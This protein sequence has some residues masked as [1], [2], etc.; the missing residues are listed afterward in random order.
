MKS[1]YFALLLA[2]AVLTWSCGTNEEPVTPPQYRISWIYSDEAYQIF[3]YD[4]AGRIVKWDYKAEANMSVASTF[5]YQEDTKSIKIKSEENLTDKDVWTFDETLYLNPDGTASHAE[6]TAILRTDG[7]HMIKNYTADFQYDSSRQLTKINTSEAVVN[8]Y[9]Q[10]GMPLDWAV[11]LAWKDNNLVKYTEYSNPDYPM[12]I[13]E[14]EYFGGQTA[15]FLPIVQGCI[16]RR[17]YLPLQYQGVLGT[18]SVGMVKTMEVVSN[19]S[20]I[21]T[22]YSY[23]MSSSIYSS[24]VEEYTEL[25]NGCESVYTVGWD[26][27]AKTVGN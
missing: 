17:Y 7:S 8:D 24:F 19:N 6:G 1:V 3:E 20:D 12:I 26:S 13:R 5:E 22:D 14:Y 16:F 11:E 9:G 15:D 2:F 4:A 25:R 21:T 18:N 23:K 10:T 27:K